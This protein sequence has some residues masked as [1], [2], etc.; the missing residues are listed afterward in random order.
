MSMQKIIS[1]LDSLR[2]R[3]RIL[4]LVQRVA[5]VLAWSLGIILGLIALD[6]LLRMPSTMRMVLLLAGLALLGYAIWRYLISALRF[7]PT[8]T[9]LALR[10]ERAL[11]A[12]S[13]RLASSVEFAAA[14][15]DQSNPL[16]ARSVRDTDSRMTGESVQSIMKPTQTLR[17]V[18][19]FFAVAVLA[20]SFVAISPGMAQTGAMR[21]LLPYSN[22]TWPART[23][24]ASL[25][26][27]VLAD[28]AVHP[29]G[30]SLALRAKV[31]R[32]DNAQRVDA[33]Y[34][35][36]VDG[37]PQPWR[38]VV[39][40]QQGQS[41]IH[42]R[43]VDTNAEAIEVWF[44]TADDRTSVQ[45]IDIVPPPAVVRAVLTTTPPAY[46]EGYASVMERQLGPGTDSRARTERPSLIGSHVELVLKF[47][48]PMPP[49]DSQHDIET[50]LGWESD[51]PLNVVVNDDRTQWTMRWELMQSRTLSMQLRD[52]HGLPSADAVSYQIDAVADHPPSVTITEPQAD[53]AVLA[54]ATVPLTAEAQDDVALATL[55][56][57]AR[58]QRGDTVSDVRW[59]EAKD[60]FAATARLATQL[61]LSSLDLAEGDVVLVQA[62]A[63]DVYELDGA[64]HEP[65]LSPIRRLRIISEVDLATQLRRQ[66]GVVRQNA[67]RIETMQSEL[68]DAISD[69]GVQLGSE[70]AQAQ[71]GER[72]AAQRDAVDEIR[73][74]MRMNQLDDQQLESLMNQSSDL[75]D[76]AGRAAGDAME[77]IAEQA[78]GRAD[79]DQAILDAQQDVRDELADLIELLDRDEDTWVI[80]R[81][82]E[83]IRS[84]QAE[85][86]AATAQ[87]HEQ[88]I[89]QSLDEMSPQDRSEL[90]RI[91]QAQRDLANDA[92]QALDD[93]RRRADA[94]EEA[95]PGAAS[96]MRRAAE[97][98]EQRG[99]EQD[100]QDAAERA[101]QNQLR[102]AQ[103]GQQAA[104]Q[105]LQRMLEDI[106]QTRR[107]E[108]EQLLRQLASLIESIERLI[109][110][111]ENEISA[112]ANAQQT[113]D[114]ANRDR[115]IIRLNQN[116]QAVATEARSAGQQTRRIARTLDRAADAQGASVTALRSEPIEDDQ[117]MQAQ[118]RSLEL[119]NEARDQAMEAQQ[120]AEQEQMRRRRAELIEAYRALMQR[121]V[122]V[123]SD[124]IPLV[125]VETLNRRQLVEARRLGSQQDQLRTGLDDLQRSNVELADSPLFSLVH[126]RMDRWSRMVTDSLQEGDVSELVTE[127]QLM[128]AQSIARLIEALEELQQPQ[129]PF[130]QD[131]G[132]EQGGGEGGSD[133]GEDELIPPITELRLLLGLQEEVY[134][135][136]KQLDARS[137]LDDVQRRQRL[138]ELGELQ[139]ELMEMGQEM[140][141]RLQ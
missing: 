86:E 93:L 65:V 14:G 126:R 106:E 68:Q 121:Q 4:L 134:N 81:Q 75:L 83:Q 117:A 63:Q 138:R 101:A 132:G 28:R 120:Q 67:V 98:A 12:M 90:E 91:A 26:D 13:G 118:E 85:L 110:V 49:L 124:V 34:R 89:G 43:L 11:P 95:D 99:L 76:F 23:G 15:I 102:N 133:G 115:A 74:Q 77:Q 16:A 30:Q 6:Y 125:E 131:E 27:E 39:L 116:T 103:V 108:V 112:L 8:L 136:T 62:T 60:V 58:V 42:E 50:M 71:I 37:A 5:V 139:R 94:M 22:A 3:S 46:A 107:A 31:T 80:T 59:I 109:F 45:R 64:Q 84:E 53:M 123:R 69:D 128:V 114:F 20:V 111:Q 18:G 79:D 52:E 135:Q 100:M 21:V 19:I 78:T 7:Y 72:I 96:A 104:A 105:T 73:Q 70:R 54:T 66:L 92:Q 55:D 40:T 36:T 61:E 56:I 44:S 82:L 24:V 29:L 57:A 122:V 1:E 140:M 33:T 25:M 41:P 9:Q 141:E 32:G 2:R 35:L 127:R 119:L 51:Q 130:A 88:T 47:N 129:D 10:V 113:G 97:T 38:Q 87:L 137:D 48:K 17:D